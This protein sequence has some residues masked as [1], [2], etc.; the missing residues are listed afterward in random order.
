M[1]IDM[2]VRICDVID[3]LTAQGIKRAQTVDRLEFGNPDMVVKGIATTFL[4]TQRVVEKAEKLEVN[5]IISHEGIFFS[6][7]DKRE[8][9]KTDPVYREKCRVIEE[10]KM[11]I[12][13]YHDYVHDHIPD[14]IMVGL[15]KELD[16]EKFE[17]KCEQTASVVEI[18]AATL[19]EIVLYIKK[20][21]NIQYVRYM[22]DLTISCRR[23]GLLV[24]YRGQGDLA[25]DLIRRENP[26]LLIYGEGPEWETPE[27]IRDS[28]QQGRQR[29]MIVLGHA[30]SEASGMKYLARY[31]QD[32]FPSIPIYFISENPVFKIL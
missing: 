15:L 31:L 4:A 1:G 19:E 23:I 16:W 27:Y 3:F 7:W 26:E 10:S 25:I 6:H 18:P 30:E 20:R 9:L 32:K 21:L 29:A 17:V 22:G 8:M 28:I 11:A 12:F 14:A 13:R 5:L 24:G 2:S